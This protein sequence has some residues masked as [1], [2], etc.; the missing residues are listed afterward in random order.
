MK[1]YCFAIDLIDDAIL[2]EEYKE[3]HRNFWPELREHTRNS[4]IKFLELYNVSNRLFM[5]WETEDDFDPE[6]SDEN[7]ESWI[8]NRSCEWEKLMSK[9]QIPLP[10][11]KP[12]E[13]WV[14]MSKIFEL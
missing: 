9:Y 13:K 12:N 6:K 7:A 3:Y 1:R 4:G 5:I 8:T 10:V 14:L 11:A 2:I